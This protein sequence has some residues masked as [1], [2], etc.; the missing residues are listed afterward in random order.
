MSKTLVTGGVRSGKSVAAETLFVDRLEVAYVATGR[1]GEQPPGRV[2]EEWAARLASHRARR[3]STWTT[4]E[5][6]DLVSAFEDAERPL[7]VDCLG[8]WLT[9]SLDRLNAWDTPEG[10]WGPRLDDLIASTV[11]ALS[12]CRHDV[13]VVTNEVGWGLV[14]EHRSGRI[15]TDRLGLLNQAVAGVCDQVLL[16]V[17]GRTVRL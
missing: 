6:T 8:T 16:V 15:F 1:A 10:Q 9:A 5:T 17:V 2:D 13:V 7:L 11:A 4:L 12:G 3:P 14:S